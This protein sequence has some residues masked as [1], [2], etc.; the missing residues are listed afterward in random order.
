MEIPFDTTCK[1]CGFEMGR[2]WVG[3][4]RNVHNLSRDAYI[5]KYYLDANPPVCKCGCGTVL[6][7]KILNNNVLVSEYTKNHWPK[8]PH[9]D[10][11]KLKIRANTIAAI[12]NKFGV[13]NVFKLDTIKDKS[14]KTK[15]DKYGDINYNNAKKNIKSQHKLFLSTIDERLLF[16][17]KLLSED[18]DGVSSKKYKF[19]HI[20][21]GTEF[22]DDIDDGHIP[23]C[24][25]CNPFINKY[26]KKHK[27][28]VE[29]IKTI[30]AGTILI[31]DRIVFG[32]EIELDIYIPDKKIA[33][34]YNGL[35]WHSD[36]HGK[37]RQYHLNKTKACYDRDIFLIHIFED[38][39]INK[40][41]ILKSK[42]SNLFG[43]LSEV[44]YARK[45]EI[46]TISRKVANEFLTQNHLQGGDVSAIRL[47][48][49]S[50]ERLL[51][52]FTLS[53]PR[54]AL[55]GNVGDGM[56][57]S[58]FAV[59]QN[60]RV[61]G[62]FSKFLSHL[63]CNYPEISTIYSYADVRY[64]NKNSNVYISNGFDLQSTSKPNYWYTKHYKKREHRFK[65]RKNVLSKNLEIFDETL[66]E[67]DNM[68]NNG[69]DRIW[70]CG[71][72]KY[73]KQIR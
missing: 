1:I 53:K 38:E 35:Y 14:K 18:Y 19:K 41:E 20:D 67:W 28:I 10:I 23:I 60:H 49:F 31:N 57:L 58:R 30:Y 62:I 52:V 59:L 27:E 73:V 7:Y 61:V 25:K 55:G 16:E 12:K 70:D 48:A 40:K 66:S 15:L 21:C 9:S 22:Y 51:S 64:V 69:Y 4:V 3:H 54:L 6:S 44:V 43:G 37:P 68:L 5:L 72:Y 56:E 47:G 34:E 63:K 65:Y 26:S 13:D 33:I 50:G 2:E 29:F 17:Y 36:T 39:W 32:N 8:K 11:I 46:R 45:C 24:R 71:N 42:L